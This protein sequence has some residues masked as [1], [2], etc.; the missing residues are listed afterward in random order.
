MLKPLFDFKQ[1]TN[2]LKAFQE[3]KEAQIVDVFS[4][5]GESFIND[6]RENGSYKDHTG[7]LRSST[8]YFIKSGESLLLKG[9]TKKKGFAGKTEGG[10]VTS[11]GRQAAQ[12]VADSIQ[13]SKGEMLLIGTAGMQYAESVEARGRDVITPMSQRAGEQ[14]EELLK[15]L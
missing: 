3:N 11:K 7:N 15:E 5:V 1:I 13:P 2:E 10:G 4:Y 12:E 8:A 6:A 14:L 9:G